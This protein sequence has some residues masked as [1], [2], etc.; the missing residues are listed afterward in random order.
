MA[1][2]YLRAGVWYLRWR[3]ASGRLQRKATTARTEK[4]ARRLL[5]ELTG[6]AERV[7]LG[8]ELAPVH[9]R[10]TLKELVEWWLE[11]R[12]PEPSRATE[13]LRLGK[14]ILRTPLAHQHLV[15]VTA[16]ALGRRFEEMEKK[17]ASAATINRLRSTLH[18]IFAAA[19][20][21]PRRWEG[22]NP[23]ADTRPRSVAKQRR[24]V[25]APADLPKVLA[26]VPEAWRGVMAVAAYLGLRKGEIFALRRS[27]YDAGRR[28][29]L[30]AGSHQR[31]TTKGDRED[32]LPV[33][34][35]LV[36]YLEAALRAPRKVA[37][38]WLFPN[39]KGGQRTRES[40]PHLVLRNAAARAGHVSY[41][42]AWCRR[43]VQEG[44]PVLHARFKTDP[45]GR[46]CTRHG[47][48]LWVHAEPTRLRFHDLRHGLGTNLAKAGV[49]LPHIQR[50]LRHASISTTINLYAHLVTEDLRASVEAPGREG[51][52]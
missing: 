48:K 36:P 19:A 44:V 7:R 43:C 27:D 13:R 12:C 2:I 46:V 32:E 50:I 16:D 45:S 14:H 40:D 9:T 31:E 4:E 26:E 33:P 29:L 41:W 23:V 52:R 3:D 22:R 1:G 15:L 51:Q 6:Q 30:V 5:A 34:E 24:E 47:C 35:V 49:P 21:P 11:E 39:R 42:E 18:S 25:L 17:G 10:L 20:R 37:S 8:L 38:V 28:T